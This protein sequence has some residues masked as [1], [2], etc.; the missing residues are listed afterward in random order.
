[1]SAR[2]FTLMELI[3]TMSIVA[4]L[5]AVAIPNFVAFK[6]NEQGSSLVS[7]LVSSLD[8]ARSEAIKRDSPVCV[9]AS[10]DGATCSASGNW[11]AGWIVY[12]LAGGCAAAA[13]VA[14]AATTLINSVIP[15][16]GTYTLNTTPAG[17]VYVGFLQ[18]GLAGQ[19]VSFK[20]C[21][22]RG[23]SYARYLEV[24]ATGRVQAAPVVGRNMANTAAL[25]CP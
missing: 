18:S 23:A 4:I 21:D 15:P 11:N 12:T 17:T 13:P 20:Y 3:V 16:S 10:S 7:S 5:A 1:M 9:C 2:G 8:Y 25:T 19:A 14:G 6:Q 22:S 24:N